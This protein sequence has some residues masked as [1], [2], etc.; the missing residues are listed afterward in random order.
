[1]FSLFTRFFILTIV[2]ENQCWNL[3]EIL[4]SILISTLFKLWSWL[5]AR[6]SSLILPWFN[7]LALLVLLEIYHCVSSFNL[8]KLWNIFLVSLP[9]ILVNCE[10]WS[11]WSNIHFPF[12]TRFAHDSLD[13][14]NQ[15]DW[16]SAIWWCISFLSCIK[17]L[18][19][20]C[21]CHS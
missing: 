18:V 3:F 15:V 5:L 8:C 12:F 19:S 7:Y 9:L 14:Y 13:S 1:M 20:I 10:I 6:I 17:W 2:V 16:E 11:D 4:D 21:I